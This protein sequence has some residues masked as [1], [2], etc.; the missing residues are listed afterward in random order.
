M[1]RRNSLFMQDIPDSLHQGK[2]SHPEKKHLKRRRV[3]RI[4]FRIIEILW[5][6][7][8]MAEHL[9]EVFKK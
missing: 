4:L 1:I 5:M 9:C 6:L 3:F 7:F 2:D 8:Q